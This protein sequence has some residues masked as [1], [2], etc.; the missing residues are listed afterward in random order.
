MLLYFYF[1]QHRDILLPS[2]THPTPGS[3]PLIWLVRLVILR[4]ID[5]EIRTKRY[6]RDDYTGMRQPNSN[7]AWEGNKIFLRCFPKVSQTSIPIENSSEFGNKE[8]L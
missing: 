1:F 7:P 6:I 5:G 4:G 3:E 2:P 8:I